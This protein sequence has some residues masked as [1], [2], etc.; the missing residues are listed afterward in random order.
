[1]KKKITAMLLAATVGTGLAFSACS[2]ASGATYY[3]VSD[4]QGTTYDESGRTKY[5][6]ALFYANYQQYGNPDPFVLDNTLRATAT[7][8]CMLRK[9]ICAH[10]VRKI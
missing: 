3:E 2:S 9:R 7:I 5:N 1:M 10:G 6:K 4:Y 8:I